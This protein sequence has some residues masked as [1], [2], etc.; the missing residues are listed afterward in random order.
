MKHLPA[1]IIID[2]LTI[3]ELFQTREKSFSNDDN[4]TLN[5]IAEFRD[6]MEKSFL[7][8]RA[9]ENYNKAQVYQNIILRTILD[10]WFSGAKNI[11]IIN[12]GKHGNERTT[13]ESSELLYKV[14]AEKNSN[15]NLTSDLPSLSIRQFPKDWYPLSNIRKKTFAVGGPDSDFS[16]WHGLNLNKVPVRNFLIVDPYFMDRWSE[17][18]VNLSE[19]LNG[20]IDNRTQQKT[21][22]LMIVIRRDQEIRDFEK[23]K[24][25]DIQDLN[26]LLRVQFPNFT[27]CASIAYVK[28]TQ[29]HDRYLFTD[30][31]YL[32]SGGGFNF[33]NKEKKF[34]KGR[35]NDLNIHLI[36]NQEVF[37]NY[38]RRLGEVF[39][40]LN[41][42]GSLYGYEGELNSK[43]FKV[44]I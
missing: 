20:L 38:R 28:K 9:K 27:F 15:D 22:N 10:K 17:T 21:F 26:D 35:S 23:K 40:W 12:P 11:E 4:R 1:E 3:E 41:S 29:T 8:F 42:S 33:Y 39:G 2:N 34:Y 32:S 30:F 13:K 31:Y 24:K 16:S 19:I 6:F 7:T 37:N 14:L 36:S 18:S 44:L 25:E 5:Y 43:L